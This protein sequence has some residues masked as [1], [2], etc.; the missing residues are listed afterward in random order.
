MEEEAP[1]KQ[2]RTYQGDIAD[3]L[4]DQKESVFSIRRAELK[5]QG[6]GNEFASRK[7]PEQEQERK[8]RVKLWFLLIGILVLL[9]VG[10]LGVWYSYTSYKTKSALPTPI[11]IPNRFIAVE[12]SVDMNVA[13]LDRDTFIPAFSLEKSASIKHNAVEQIQLKQGTS[14]DARIITTEE[15]LNILN[16][17][18]PGALV[19]AF[20]P[21]FMIGLIGDTTE[22]SSTP[23]TFVLIKLDSYDNAFAGMLSWETDM[24]N[25]LLPLFTNSETI[26]SLSATTT[27]QDI[28][29]QNKNARAVKDANG[30]TIFLYSFLGNNTLILTDNETDLNALVARL[31]AEKLSR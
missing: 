10:G 12:T 5:K 13:G 15:F 29:T 2:I 18:A 17:K 21:L 4:R 11:I 14:T 6:D 20:D 9:V 27:F 19:R 3:A 22:A 25:D 23:H 31:N 28:T 8:S 30:K 16:T 24:Q 26:S 1:L 7:T